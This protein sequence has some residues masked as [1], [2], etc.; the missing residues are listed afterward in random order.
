MIYFIAQRGILGDRNFIRAGKLDQIVNK[1]DVSKIN[2]YPVLE[3]A[4]IGNWS[5]MDINHFINTEQFQ[6]TFNLG[7][8]QN[9]GVELNPA[10]V[11]ITFTFTE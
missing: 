4:D 3:R 10:G 6:A 11:H 2:G 1:P 7:Y 5:E 9:T 8:G